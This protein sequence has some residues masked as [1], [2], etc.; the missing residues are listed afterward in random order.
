MTSPI[1][2]LVIVLTLALGLYQIFRA[3]RLFRKPNLLKNHQA[4]IY[5]VSE[6]ERRRIF[7]SEEPETAINGDLLCH[8]LKTGKVPALRTVPIEA[9]PTITRSRLQILMVIGWGA[10]LILLYVYLLL[11]PS[12]LDID[13]VIFHTFSIALALILAGAGLNAVAML[14]VVLIHYWI[15]ERVHDAE[16]DKK[17]A[18]KQEAGQ[19]TA[20]KK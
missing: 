8:C 16:G 7:R 11:N 6:E 17:S 9:L 3:L 5:G 1:T 18:E 12:A 10:A 13:P 2:Y 19:K 14:R 4:G 15:A 20:A